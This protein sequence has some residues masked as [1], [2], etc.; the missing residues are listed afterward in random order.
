VGEPR[1]AM[2]DRCCPMGDPRPTAVE[3]DEVLDYRFCES[4]PRHGLQ[5]PHH[6]CLMEAQPENGQIDGSIAGHSSPLSMIRR[7]F[8]AGAMRLPEQVSVE[9]QWVP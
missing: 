4:F 6:V 8:P 3:Q 5:E 1:L 9:P 2:G 7:A